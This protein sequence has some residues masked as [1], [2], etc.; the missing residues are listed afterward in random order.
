MSKKVCLSWWRHVHLAPGLGGG[1]GLSRGGQNHHANKSPVCSWQGAYSTP[2][3]KHWLWA[4]VGWSTHSLR[5]TP[6]HRSLSRGQEGTPSDRLWRGVL[7]HRQ[8]PADGRV[9]LGNG[10]VGLGAGAGRGWELV[11]PR[12]RAYH[13]GRHLAPSLQGPRGCTHAACCLGPPAN[14]PRR[15]MPCSS[16]PGLAPLS[17][18]QYCLPRVAVHG[19]GL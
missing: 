15:K 10:A 13:P 9:R 6:K 18:D 5:H 7:S 8:A 14:V 3:L 11:H 2:M 12:V 19:G 1:S 17:R 4:W 16:H